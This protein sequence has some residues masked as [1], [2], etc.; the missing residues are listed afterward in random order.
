METSTPESAPSDAVQ[1]AA[2]LNMDCFCRTLDTSRLA[3]ELAH[4]SGDPQFLDHH[5]ASRPFL[6]SQVPV[7]APGSALKAMLE[8]I[9]AIETVIRSSAYQSLA[10]ERA[11]ADLVRDRGPIGA[12]M[13]Y[14]FHLQDGPPRLIEV[15]TNAGGAFLNAAS[16]R[17]H[18]S[19]CAE[20]DVARNETWSDRFEEACADMFRSEWRRFGRPAE[21]LRRVAIIDDNPVDQFLYPEFILARE[22]FRRF[23]IEAVILDPSDLDVTSSGLSAHGA[24]IDLIYNRLT[25]FYLEEPPHAVLREALMSNRVV[26]TPDPRAHCLYA[27]KRNLILLSDPAFTAGLTLPQHLRE[28]LDSLPRTIAL[29]PDNAEDLW[30]KRKALFFKPVAGFG[31]KA[32]YRGDKL[33]RRVWDEILGSAYVAQDFA[34]PGERRMLVD[35]ETVARKID[36]RIYTYDGSP[37]LA[38]ARLYQGQTT[39]FRTPGGGFAPIFFV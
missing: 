31:G 14:D 5:V 9:D 28:A 32:V 38:A 7:F 23:G 22:T 27:D 33:T 37:L 11:P 21:T 4:A 19:C 20:M 24:P 16:A 29:T 10:L 30:R 25:D 39:N 35:Q 2:A 1:R 6:L 26:V 36:I 17:A 8:T 18:K 34:T 13:G 3:V 12:L 15:N